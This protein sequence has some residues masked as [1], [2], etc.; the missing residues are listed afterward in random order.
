MRKLVF[1]LCITAAFST[2]KAV[3]GDYIVSPTVENSDADHWYYI[4]FS[5]YF[6]FSIIGV[7]YRDRYE[8]LITQFPAQDT[9][10]QLWKIVQAEPGYYY[11]VNKKEGKE[12]RQVVTTEENGARYRLRVN[13][14]YPIS[15]FSIDKDPEGYRLHRKDDPVENRHFGQVVNDNGLIG[16]AILDNK[17]AEGY[18]VDFIKPEDIVFPTPFFSKNAIKI[19]TN[20]EEPAVTTWCYI[21]FEETGNV[22]QY[23]GANKLLTANPLVE[24]SAAQLW[25]IYSGRKTNGPGYNGQYPII[26]KLSGDTITYI[27]GGPEG[28][29][30]G[31]YTRNGTYPE[32][33]DIGFS[34][35]MIKR[36]ASTLPPHFLLRANVDSISPNYFMQQTAGNHSIALSNN[37]VMINS[38]IRFVLEGGESIFSPAENHA[39]EVYP[40][41]AKDFISVKLQGNVTSVSIVNSV[42]QTVSKVKPS[43][44]IEKLNVSNFAPGIYFLKVEDLT[45]VKTAKF[46][47]K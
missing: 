10:S 36:A 22:I 24:G 15:L 34:G 46:M 33:A 30:N 8:D 31:F 7:D 29:A 20:P 45:G 44:A 17:D 14:S 47:K 40:N 5:D 35:T 26:N 25:A 27:T 6:D 12:L 16:R 4:Q 23:N 39:V 38:A 1:I 13:E 19:G 18:Y 2:G 28:G 41:P 42:G 21:Q 32:G 3:A 11:L 43:T 37:G 9:I